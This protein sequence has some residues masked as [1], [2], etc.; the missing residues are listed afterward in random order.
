M[1]LICDGLDLSDAVLK[2]S[3]ALSV[4]A[5]NPILEGIKISAKGDTLT[6]LATDMELTIERTIKAD[7]LMEGETV[8][9]G[10]YFVDFVKKLE[11]E[12][13]ELSRL[14]DGQLK[15]KYG[16]SESELQVFPAENFPKIEKDAE[17]N[18]FEISQNDFKEVVERTAFACSTDDARPILK[19]CL[20]EIVDGTLTAVALDGFRMALV[21]KQV[22]SLNNMKAVI[23][24]RALNEI[25]RLFDKEEGILK[26]YLQKNSLFVQIE[27]TCLISRLIE[28]EFVKYNHILPTNFE[29]TVTINRAMLLTSIERA[30]IVARNDRYN[31]IK[32]D[33]KED[34]VS[35][36]AK[37]EIGTVNENVASILDGKD[38]VIA[39]NG[40]YLSEYL[41]I[42]T[43]EFIK[44]NLNTNIDPC[45]I[46]PVGGEGFLYLVLPVRIN[47]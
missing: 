23:P 11:K 45:V 28:G 47:A 40:K 31:V 44:L 32:F 8:V 5:A 38:M 46:T 19:G 20:F 3:K 2:V 37:S 6:L 30:S 39:F 16:D 29:N 24:A 21:K 4:K 17:E 27:N 43:D 18:Y 41:K 13:I 35:V 42:V 34:A 9:V 12:Q 15:I 36:S 10:K 7:V 14:F 1:K 33:I 22:I 25:V 26:V